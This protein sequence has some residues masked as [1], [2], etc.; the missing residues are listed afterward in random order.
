MNVTYGCMV[1]LLVNSEVQ[2]RADLDGYIL[3]YLNNITFTKTQK[4]FLKSDVS[5]YG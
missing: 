1:K 5:D 4:S 2:M 3:L